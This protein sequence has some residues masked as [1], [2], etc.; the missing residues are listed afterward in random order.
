MVQLMGAT[1]SVVSES[2]AKQVER[3]DVV[4]KLQAEMFGLS[5]ASF[6]L[7]RSIGAGRVQTIVAR[8]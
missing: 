5:A 8:Q 3:F 2:M 7:G 4:D 6:G 1:S